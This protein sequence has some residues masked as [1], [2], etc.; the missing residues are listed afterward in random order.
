MRVPKFFR[1]RRFRRPR[2]QHARI[3]Q[4]APGSAVLFE[5]LEQRV[6][7]SASPLGIAGL[8]EQAVG[9]MVHT[10]RSPHAEAPRLNVGNAASASEVLRALR[11]GL[12]DLAEWSGNLAERNANLLETDLPVIGDTLGQAL[13]GAGSQ[14][15]RRLIEEGSIG[16]FDLDDI[17][18]DGTINT[19][20][21]LLQKLEGL[22]TTPN[23]VTLD[24]KN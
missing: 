5:P 17:D 2:P 20:R 21:K 12:Q 10:L 22:D 11:G 23:N 4:T 3:R 15:L 6:L 19:A 13:N 9:A 7:L 16:A 24:E 14:L 18:I 8:E 1:P